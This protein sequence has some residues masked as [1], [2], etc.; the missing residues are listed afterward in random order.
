MSPRPR[1]ISMLPI[2]LLL[3]AGSA[4]ADVKVS[5]PSLACRGGSYAFAIA[6]HYP[7]LLNIG[8]HRV[9]QLEE[10]QQGNERITLRR[11]EYIGMTLEVQVSSLDP[12]RYQLHQA[13][14]WSRRWNIGRLS[15]GRRPWLSEP[16]PGLAPTALNGTLELV[17]PVDAVSLRL[18]DGRVERVVFRCSDRAGK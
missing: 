2:W 18:A 1:L 14:V 10:R 15:V 7:T 4:G 9:L 16:E 17:G 6:E 5:L 11:I 12:T 13:E 3:G 8:R